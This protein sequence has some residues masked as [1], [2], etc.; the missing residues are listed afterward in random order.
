MS[1]DI[2]RPKEC[3]L[4][5]PVC[6]QE[7]E[8]GSSTCP[9][10]GA[11]LVPTLSDAQRKGGWQVTVILYVIAVALVAVFAVLILGWHEEQ[12]KTMR[13]EQQAAVEA[14]LDAEEALATE[15]SAHGTVTGHQV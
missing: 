5:C 7:I 9:K 8:P 6:Q 14:E 3:Q 1:K 15:P 12:Q 13:L 11:T 2:I 4:T 10:C